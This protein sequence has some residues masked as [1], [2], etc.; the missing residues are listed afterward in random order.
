MEKGV[1]LYRYYPCTWATDI[2]GY[3]KAG[4]IDRTLNLRMSGDNFTF[5]IAVFNSDKKWRGEGVK[6]SR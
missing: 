3:R 6:S 2:P 5:S 4:L 1:L